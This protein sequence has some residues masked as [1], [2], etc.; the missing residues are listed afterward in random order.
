MEAALFCAR[1]SNGLIA[2]FW[3]EYCI[4]NINNTKSQDLTIIWRISKERSN[5]N[6]QIFDF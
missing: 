1:I 3:Q 4:V 5:F 2:Q 6:G